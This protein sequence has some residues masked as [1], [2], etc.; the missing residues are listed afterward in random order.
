MSATYLR[1]LEAISTIA[2][3]KI[4]FRNVIIEAQS[5]NLTKH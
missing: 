4:I 1:M 2:V 5:I 3:E